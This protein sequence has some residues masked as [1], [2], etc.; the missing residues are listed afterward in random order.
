ML[1]YIARRVLLAFFAVWVISM[2]SWVIIQLPE[3]D[4]VD[5]YF[6]ALEVGGDSQ[7]HNEERMD[8]MAG[9]PRPR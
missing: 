8:A 7:G 1:P 6:W 9:V 2:L 5:T 3:G 4:A